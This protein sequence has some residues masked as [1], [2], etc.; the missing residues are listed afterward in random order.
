M[1][2]VLPDLRP[3]PLSFDEVWNR[4][5]PLATDL[6]LDPAQ[7]GLASLPYSELNGPGFERL[8]YEL[9][10]SENQRPWFFGCSGQAQYGIDIVTDISGEQYVY[11][12]KNYAVVPSWPEVRA[13]LTKFESEWLNDMSLP[14]PREFVY[15]CPQPLNDEKFL[16][17]WE[18]FK[19]A[20]QKR[21]GVA[22]SFWDRNAI[23]S[24]L[25]RLP[26][27]VAGLFSDSYAELFCGRD[28]WR[29]DP[30]IRVQQ[31]PGRF[32]V[33]N[34][35]LD[36]HNRQAIYI[37]EPHEKLFLT[38]LEQSS[39]VAIRGLP[40]MGKSFLALELSCRLRQPLR[41]IYYATLKDAT[42]PERLWQSA[43][44]RLS[45]PSVFVLDDCHLDLRAVDTLLERLDPEIQSG[46]LKII[47]NIRDQVGGGAD[48]LDDT[49]AW[50]AQ[51]KKEDAII[52]LRVDIERTLGV[53]LQ[54]RTDFTGLSRS[55]LK[56]LHKACGGDLLLLDQILRNLN[57]PENIDTLNV[58]GLLASVRDNYFGSNRPLPTLAKL[59]ALAQFD[60]VPRADFFEGQW[61]PGEEAAADPLMT[62]L[63]GPQRYQFLHSSLATLVLRAL[64]QLNTSEQALDEEVAAITTDTLSDYFLHLGETPAGSGEFALALHQLLGTQ[65]HL[66]SDT[67]AAG[68]V[69]AAV[70]GNKQ[71]QAVIERNLEDQS[72]DNLGLCIRALTDTD[73]PAK[74]DYL[75]LIRQRFRILFER[76]NNNA[77]QI[78]MSTFG[79]GLLALEK[80]APE[81]QSTIL[82]EHGPEAFLSIIRAAGTLFEFLKLLE[83]TMPGFRTR[84]FDYF[85]PE[86][87]KTLIDKTIAAGR[88]IG[89]VGLA[90]RELADADPDALA[91]LEQ[92]IGAPGFVRLIL[93]NGTL[94]ELFGTLQYASPTFR[95]ALLDELTPTHAEVLIDKTIAAGRSIGTL[96]FAMRELGDTDPEML[97]R[98]EQA[99]GAPAFLR[100]ILANGTLFEM[101]GTLKHSN[102][103]FRTALLDQ[104]SA[105][106]AEILIDKTIAVGR[107]IGTLNFAMRKVGDANPKV[108]A[109]L[110]RTIGVPGFVRLILAN[111]TVFELFR[112][113]EYSTL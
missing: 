6:S 108:L 19:D 88:S 56:K 70:I 71:I 86:Q 46:K 39:A 30:W 81:M 110:E 37:A 36:R 57:T 53:I 103:N 111:G 87:A 50:L 99:I 15:C 29:N 18:T 97:A 113:L 22:V 65:P 101:F 49:P 32:L 102:P 10:L 41:R 67:T 84:L 25:R 112:I 43:R 105:K 7:A 92:A 60:L 61:E 45:L 4:V 54:L 16:V 79:S 24:R 44:R 98:L 28:E 77:D 62:R 35:F 76:A 91:R 83:N 42:S 27:L 63:F 48:Q 85:T 8:I 40:G 74:P 95:S 12:C 93:A 89:T 58:D 109:R 82:E 1:N 100:L 55:R 13:A 69:R 14:A 11:Q 20:F 23:D 75:E 59:A 72:F 90:M 2:S 38:A 21:T 31:G 106:E 3:R 52:D 104:F 94:F 96:T 51:L 34:R 80:F 66:S 64:A 17:E 47:L 33:V 68:R 78:G 26:D 73:H 107:S 5:D 9:L